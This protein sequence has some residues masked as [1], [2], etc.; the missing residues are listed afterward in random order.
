MSLPIVLLF[1]WKCSD[2]A[3]RT[4]AWRAQ[5]HCTSIFVSYF[6]PSIGLKNVKVY[7]DAVCSVCLC[8]CVTGTERSGED[9]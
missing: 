2:I 4:E 3:S 9:V 7:K 8:A 1:S 5:S 6:A